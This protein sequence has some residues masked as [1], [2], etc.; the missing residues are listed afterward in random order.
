MRQVLDSEHPVEGE[1][2]MGAWNED[3]ASGKDFIY[4]FVLTFSCVT[5]NVNLSSNSQ[6]LPWVASLT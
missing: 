1:Q 3:Q 5:C 4:L 6:H 2:E